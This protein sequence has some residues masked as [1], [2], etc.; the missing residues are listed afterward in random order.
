M[1]RGS[2]QSVGCG[3]GT[4]VEVRYA[5]WQRQWEGRCSGVLE[6]VAC[7]R[8]KDHIMDDQRGSLDSLVRESVMRRSIP[9][10]PHEVT[11]H[12]SIEAYRV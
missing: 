2:S 5:E 11:K 3:S 12:L 4:G 6:A 1:I 8:L 7:K 10:E 9:R